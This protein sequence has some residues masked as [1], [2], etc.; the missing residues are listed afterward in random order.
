[1]ELPIAPHIEGQGVR[2]LSLALSLSL[3]LSLSEKGGV[4]L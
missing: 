2:S 4:M 1:M 3:S